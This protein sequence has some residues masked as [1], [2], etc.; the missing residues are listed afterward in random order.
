MQ[1]PLKAI[2]AGQFLPLVGCF[3]QRSQI[4]GRASSIEWI[5]SQL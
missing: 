4:H 3:G 2:L 1:Y 5:A